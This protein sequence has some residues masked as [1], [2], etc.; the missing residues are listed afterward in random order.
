[1]DMMDEEDEQL[2]LAIQMS[3]EEAE[4]TKK[5]EEML[6]EAL[7]APA[8]LE[9]TRTVD[10]SSP[11][12]ID[13]APNKQGKLSEE[14]EAPKPNAKLW[15]LENGS[16]D[17]PPLTHRKLRPQSERPSIGESNS[18]ANTIV[19]IEDASE[20]E[21]PQ[22]KG[23]VRS[24]SQLARL[25]SRMS[26]EQA[27]EYFAGTLSDEVI[28]SL[29][30][31]APKVEKKSEAPS[32]GPRIHP[33]PS[34]YQSSS[35]KEEIIVVEREIGSHA[36]RSRQEISA[37]FSPQRHFRL[38]WVS[39]M[40]V[41]ER[42]RTLSGD[43]LPD[44]LRL[45]DLI[46]ADAK[47]VWLTTFKI[48]LTWLLTAVPMLMKVPSH[49]YHGDE[50]DI[51]Q[52]GKVPGTLTNSRD[53]LW[54]FIKNITKGRQ[55]LPEKAPFVAEK[56]VSDSYRTFPGTP[57]AKLVLVQYQNFLRVAISTA[58]L[59][60]SDWESKT[61]GIWFQDFPLKGEDGYQSFCSPNILSEEQTTKVRALSKEFE[62]S[63]KDYFC[64]LSRNNFD[65]SLFEKYDYRNVRVSLVTS[66]IGHVGAESAKSYGYMKLA[67][68]LQREPQPPIGT[69]EGS[70]T[71]VYAQMSSLG[72]ISPKYLSELQKAFSAQRP[73]FDVEPPKIESSPVPIASKS[74]SK[75][76]NNGDTIP[77]SLVWPSVEFVR[78]CHEGWAAGGSLCAT[79]ANMLNNKAVLSST[80]RYEPKQAIRSN[81]SPHIKSYWRTYSDGTLGWMCLSSANFSKSAWGEM[82]LNGTRLS[83]SNFEVGVV[84]LPSVLSIPA[85][86]GEDQI[87]IKKS[88]SNNAA[89][90]PSDPV[91]HRNVRL[92]FGESLLFQSD[93]EF[94][95]ITLPI[96]FRTDAAP[97]P[98]DQS[99]TSLHD[100]PWVW[101]VARAERDSLGVGFTGTSD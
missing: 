82:Q 48:D 9:R 19:E 16:S 79:T 92:K 60:G 56:Y 96:P 34:N 44:T 17:L 24:D 59:C 64:R 15:G 10:L 70:T 101:D 25:L 88:N 41:P 8:S 26:N 93:P 74:K 67:S 81:I 80:V 86:F 55:H 97:F 40:E 23:A 14:E 68:V 31:E 90:S 33:H 54:E 52:G 99:R 85:S 53:R 22:K 62:Q 29:L 4:R 6:K 7:A 37:H 75:L 42:G 58:N 32:N 61:Q 95:N 11:E 36:N 65:K 13:V 35:T 38:N 66:F 87:I 46:G 89:R 5:E 20:R 77:L 100:Q 2:K 18:R 21:E 76:I 47:R 51:Y 57:H 94:L 84:L 39:T 45:R 12:K 49:I 28:R 83:M 30:G 78:T 71:R 69:Q 27:D 3:L 91:Q 43:R 50:M 73:N 1:M 72:K 63:L 98:Q